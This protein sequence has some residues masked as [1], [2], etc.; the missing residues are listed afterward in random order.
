M[1]MM[2]MMIDVEDDVKVP[3]P[4]PKSRISSQV[5][6]KT[7]DSEDE[8]DEVDEMEEKGDQFAEA[9]AHLEEFISSLHNSSKVKN[10]TQ[11]SQSLV[12]ELLHA[13]Q[14]LKQKEFEVSLELLIR[15]VAYQ[16]PLSNFFI[17]CES[18]PYI[19]AEEVLSDDNEAENTSI[20]NSSEALVN[21]GTRRTNLIKS[22]QV[23]LSKLSENLLKFIRL[24]RK[25]I[26]SD[27]SV[28][29]L[30]Q[31]Y[32]TIPPQ[33]LQ[34][35]GA[36]LN[37][38]EV[39][40]MICD[41]TRE[42]DMFYQL[43][44]I[45]KFKN[46]RHFLMNHLIDKFCSRDV[47]TLT[48]GDARENILII[49]H[50]L[51]IYKPG[52]DKQMNKRIDQVLKILNQYVSEDNPYQFREN[53]PSVVLRPRS[54][55][56]RD[57]GNSDGNGKS[58]SSKS[59]KPKAKASKSSTSSQST[60]QNSSSLQ[61]SSSTSPMAAVSSSTNPMATVAVEVVPI[62]VAH[63]VPQR[64]S[65]PSNSVPSNILAEIED[66]LYSTSS[67]YTRR[68]RNSDQE[69]T[70][71]HTSQKPFRTVDAESS[72]MSQTPDRTVVH[73]SQTQDRTVAH[74]NQKSYRTVAAELSFASVTPVTLPEK[75]QQTVLTYDELDQMAGNFAHVEHDNAAK[76][77]TCLKFFSNVISCTGRNL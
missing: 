51:E 32:R 56:S 17:M 57:Y 13:N 45:K 49:M 19:F 8:E 1:M 55:L 50:N 65:V 22:A 21:N 64:A 62:A 2:M 44:R 5:V 24:Y 20:V 77:R 40:K 72:L 23:Y 61:G 11:V 66:S 25:Q 36:L 75:H 74:A 4:K 69:S 27:D 52:A 29:I 9:Q 39:R 63:L 41:V 70:V 68:N 58:K 42:D 48:T 16:Q 71:A 15:F 31:L 37:L 6:S 14:E 38:A 46:C 18:A 34:K 76:R 54:S 60:A 73:T 28:D 10:S 12:I 59:A 30:A 67:A 33:T 7:Q 3:N 26:Q 35:Y 47:I 43:S 53:L